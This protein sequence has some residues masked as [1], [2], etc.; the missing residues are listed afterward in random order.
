[1]QINAIHQHLTEITQRHIATIRD[2]RLVFD[3]VFS[4]LLR[5]LVEVFLPNSIRH[6]KVYCGSPL[7]GYPA[8]SFTQIMNT[9]NAYDF[10]FIGFLLTVNMLSDHRGPEYVDRYVPAPERRQSVT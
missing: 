2:V 4:F 9:A 7:W 8:H 10:P 3:K 1:M 6:H 5:L